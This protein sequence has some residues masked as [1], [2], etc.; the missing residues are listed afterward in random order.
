MDKHTWQSL[1]DSQRRLWE[2]LVE[3]ENALD[4]LPT[5]A[6]ASETQAESSHLRFLLDIRHEKIAAILFPSRHG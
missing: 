5:G 3:L 1:L 2:S 4:Q 6:G